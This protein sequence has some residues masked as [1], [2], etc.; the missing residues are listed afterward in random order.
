MRSQ[1]IWAVLCHW[2]LTWD[3]LPSRCPWRHHPFPPG[4]CALKERHAQVQLTGAL[5]ETGLSERLG[6]HRGGRGP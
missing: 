5:T 1:E 2:S 6:F 4:T 3:T